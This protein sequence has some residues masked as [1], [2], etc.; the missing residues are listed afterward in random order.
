MALNHKIQK[1]KR[2]GS[3]GTTG[4]ESYSS[5]EEDNVDLENGDVTLRNQM[6]RHGYSDRAGYAYSAVNTIT[7]KALMSDR[8]SSDSSMYSDLDLEKCDLEVISAFDIKDDSDNKSAA[9]GSDQIDWS[10]SVVSCKDH[11]VLGLQ[12]ELKQVHRQLKVKDEELARVNRIRQD[13]EAELEDLTASLFQEAHNMVREANE[14]QAA[15]E[16]ALKESQMKVDVLTAEV[17]ALKTL[18]LTSTPSSPNPHLHPQIS[19]DETGVAIFNKKHRRSPSHYN[20]RY[21]RENSPPDSPIKE[22]S[23]IAISTVEIDCKDEQ[24][25]DPVFHKEFL[26][27]RKDPVLSKTNTFIQRIYREDITMCLEFSNKDLMEK[28][29]IS[30]EDGSVLVEA[31]GDKTKAIFP[32]TCALLQVPRLCFYRMRVGEDDTWYTISQICRNRIIAVCDFLNYLKYIQRGLVKSS[33][34]DVYWQ[35][36]KLR[37]NMSLAR[38]GLELTS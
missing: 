26:T 18:V 29:L 4:D 20:L 15:A 27:W 8:N 17:A 36:I 35:I 6:G 32:K 16:K 28:L 13:V 21:G 12:D 37:K 7:E 2:V 10:G 22:S 19:K 3:T 14:K 25:V 31:V 24:E 23:G 34:H 1:H 11:I 30:V 9:S 33:A 5:D 38:L